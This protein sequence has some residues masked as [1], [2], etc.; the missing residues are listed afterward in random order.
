MRKILIFLTILTCIVFLILL[1]IC[2]P[3]VNSGDSGEFIT[4]SCT[5]GVAHSPGY[6]LYSLI[7]KFFSNILLFGNYAYRI[8][9]MNIIFSVLILSFFVYFLVDLYNKDRQRVIFSYFLFLTFIFS[10]SYLRNTV[11]TEVFVLN[12]FMALVILYLL[13]KMLEN[14]NLNMLLLLFFIFGLAMGNHHTIV[15]LVPSLLLIFN[16]IFS[17]KKI[18]LSLLFFILGFSIYLVLPLRSS[19]NP[20]F[21]W[22]NTEKINNLYKVITRKDYGTFQ[23]T[24]E[25]PLKYSFGNILNQTK[26]FFTKEIKDLSILLFIFILASSVVLFLQNRRLLFM[27]IC[28]YFLSGVFFVCLS[29]LPFGELY[30]GILERFYIFPNF[31]GILIVVFATKYINKNVLRFLFILVTINF[32]YNMFKNTK[33]CDYRN[34]YLNYDY[35][36]NI[37]RTLPL[38]SFLFMDG[39][40][41]TFYTLGYLQAVEKKRQDLKL[42]DRGGLV[43]RNVYGDDFRKLTKEEKEVRRRK[44]EETYSLNYPLFYSTFNKNILPGKELKFMGVLYAVRSELL[45]SWLDA[46]LLYQIYSYRSLYQDYYDYRSKAL[47]PIYLFMEAVNE[48]I[49][50]NKI[51]KLKYAYFKWKEVDWLKNNVLIEL[52]QCGYDSII[53]NIY[54]LALDIYK[55]II[56]INSYDVNAILNLGVVL[57]K[58]GRIEEAEEM[59]KKAIQ[60][61]PNNPTSYYNLGSIYWQKNDWEKVIEY[62]EKVVELQP[63]NQQVRYYLQRAMQQRNK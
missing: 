60:L 51:K 15:F 3:S 44:V 31:I 27:L 7:G 34:Y 11:Q 52:H 38:N 41:D 10:E 50:I 5:L 42:H 33:L 40:D 47:V 13:W 61:Q 54:S 12:I 62:F 6:P 58:L 14:S 32:I 30:E 46:K 57:E 20:Y 2:S 24:V 53:N 25:S 19:K 56:Y 4:T 63:E 36:I 1:Y 45:P 22:G 26:R 55:T 49:L 48:D 17:L 18:L 35:G 29:N 8:N 21:D 59:Y 37:L 39:G 43:F 28:P 16:K 23:L 9:V